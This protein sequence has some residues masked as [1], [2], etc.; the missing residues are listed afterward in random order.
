[1]MRG[2]IHYYVYFKIHIFQIGIIITFLTGEH[3]VFID[4]FPAIFINSDLG[5]YII[6][7]VGCRQCSFSVREFHI[8]IKVSQLSFSEI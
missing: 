8:A 6:L 1:M 7:E 5:I 2:G 3:S 4:H